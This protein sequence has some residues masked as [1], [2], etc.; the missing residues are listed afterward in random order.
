MAP[1]F[2]F[3]ADI[4]S[5][6]AYVPGQRPPAG[7]SAYKLSSNENPFPPSSAVLSAVIDAAAD[8]NRYP[9]M[10]A[11]ALTAAIA[12][13]V[14]VDAE[15]VVVGNGSVAVLETVLQAA[16]RPGDEVVHAWRSFEAYPIAVQV[17]GARS[18]PVPLREDG[19]HDLSAM[20]DAVTD[21]TRVVLVCTP[22]NPTGTVV[23]EDEMRAFLARVPREVLVV[24]D[25]AYVEYVHDGAA[26]D[27]LA[28]AAEFKNVLVLRTFSKA[29]GLAGL[30]VGYAVARPRLAR[31]LR[32]ASTPFGV[33]ALAQA[34]ALAALREA[35]AVAERCERVVAERSRVLAALREMG[36]TV[37]ESHGNFYWL[38]IGRH[39]AS[40]AREA[41]GTGAMVRAF[42]GEGVRVSIGEVEGNDLVL[43]LA[44][45]WLALQRSRA[46]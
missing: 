42:D 5:L 21:R 39:S 29:Y 35:D 44:G 13:H 2:R 12:G 7:R 26:A 28:L 4:D 14:G 17:A 34:A 45:E 8:L 9:D 16:C 18:V 43:R 6:P 15:R 32:T 3:R 25:E 46:L 23:R 41:A 19:S 38:G 31:G 40:F 10:A 27:G 11:T 1:A 33:N 30:R 24:V 22:N 37:P 20:A 36:W